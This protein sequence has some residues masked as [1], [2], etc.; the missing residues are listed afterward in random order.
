[1]RA[2][3]ELLGVPTSILFLPDGSI[4][5]LYRVKAHTVLYRRLLRCDRHVHRTNDMRLAL[6]IWAVSRSS[7]QDKIVQNAL[8]KIF[9]IP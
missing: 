9:L 6:S 4:A 7:L 8:A 2:D 1:M 3:F 5:T